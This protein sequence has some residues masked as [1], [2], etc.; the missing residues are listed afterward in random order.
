M[1][2]I[3]TA[4]G[5]GL[6][7]LVYFVI[8]YLFVLASVIFIHELGHFSMGRLFK[9]RINTFAIGFGP[10]IIGFTDRHGTRWKISA[11]PLGGFVKFFGDADGSSRMDGDAERKM[12]AQERAES[13]HFRPIWQRALVVLAGPVANFVLAICIFAATFMIQGRA[14]TIPVAAEALKDS[15]AALA[16]F[17]RGDRVV[18]VNGRAVRSVDDF[19]VIVQANAGTPLSIAI[20]RAGA[21]V[22]LSVTPARIEQKTD[23]GRLNIGQIG[24]KFEW[25][26]EHQR[27]ESLGPIQALVAGVEQ[28]GTILRQT[29]TFLG[30]LFSGREN[31]DQLNGPLGIANITGHVAQNGIG[32]LFWLTAVLSFSIG[33]VNLFPI[34]VLDGG[35]LTFYILEAIRRKPLGERMQEFGY[36]VGFGLI[37]ALLVVV[38]FNDVRKL[39]DILVG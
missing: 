18:S 1:D 3:A 27:F 34:P 26:E 8:A 6:H 12:T 29:G 20:D 15:P 28:C 37:L 10:E 32:N 24:L 23:F 13:F 2:M 25:R 5:A 31:L 17:Q 35:H 19:V 38:S 21:P 16:G 4:L 7:F 30:R 39:I 33:L 36:R 14:Y 22:E 9:M 11:I